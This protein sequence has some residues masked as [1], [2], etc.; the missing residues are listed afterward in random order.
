MYGRG[1]RGSGVG[2][3]GRGVAFEEEDVGVAGDDDDAPGI[4]G[5]Y[6]RFFVVAEGISS[7]VKWRRSRSAWSQAGKPARWPRERLIIRMCSPPSLSSA[8]VR[9]KSAM[10]G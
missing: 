3:A 4:V 5:V 6:V 8:R 9:E 10:R 2:G 7:W 1:G